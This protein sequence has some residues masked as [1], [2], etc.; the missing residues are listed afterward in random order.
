MSQSQKPELQAVAD[1]EVSDRPRRRKFGAKYKL[2]ILREVDSCTEEGQIGAILRR[3]GLY[4]SHISKWRQA[5]EAG[6][7]LAL[8]PKKRGRPRKP[9]DPLKPEVDRLEREN[10]KLQEELRKA[11]L[12]ID[13]QKKLSEI[14]NIPLGTPT[15]KSE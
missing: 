5:R 7:L 12:I 10:A 4:S 9:S 11:Q 8:M 3:E 14:L 6:D 15:E 13:V 2:E 1:P